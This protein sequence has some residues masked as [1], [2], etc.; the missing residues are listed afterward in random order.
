[1]SKYAFLFVYELYSNSSFFKCTSLLILYHIDDIDICSRQLQMSENK[2]SDSCQQ[3]CF[4]LRKISLRTRTGGI[5]SFVLIY[6]SHSHL[7]PDLC[8]EEDMEHAMA[9]CLEAI[10]GAMSSFYET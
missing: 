4:Q 8:H 1:M 2:V 5:V 6:F 10:L 7:R 3:A 9:N